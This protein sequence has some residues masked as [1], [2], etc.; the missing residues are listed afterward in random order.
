M[1]PVLVVAA[2]HPELAPLRSALG[3]RLEGLVGGRACVAKA[4]GIG[5]VNAAVGTSTRLAA[6]APRAVV[7]IGT[8]GAYAG[9]PAVGEVIAA[10]RVRFVEPAVVEGRAAIPEPMSLVAATDAGLAQALVGAGA[11]LADVATTVGVTTDDALAARIAQASGCEVEHLEAF[12]V[13]T[14]CAAV[15]VP[16]AAA[17][18]VANAVGSRARDEWKQNHR[19]AAE[20]AASVALAALGR[21]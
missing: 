8:C 13:A 6:L 3:D 5:L 20:R 12:A 14:A 11:R 1:G 16:F 21:V 4:V 10:R 17:L 19:A 15:G 7:L 18:A 9:G 2:F